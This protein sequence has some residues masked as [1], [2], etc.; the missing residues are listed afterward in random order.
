MTICPLWTTTGGAGGV[1]LVGGFGNRQ[2]SMGGSV[3]VLINWGETKNRTGPIVGWKHAGKDNEPTC[4]LALPVKEWR[5]ATNPCFSF[6][7][8]RSAEEV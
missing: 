5:V 8:L 6:V 1:E 2:S 7:S 3:L 4:P